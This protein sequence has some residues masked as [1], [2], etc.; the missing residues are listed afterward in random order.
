MNRVSWLIGLTVL[1][2]PLAAV[3]AQS[4]GNGDV[5]GDGVVNNADLQAVIR[6]WNTTSHAADQYGDGFVNGMDYTYVKGKIPTP[7]P[8]TDEWTQFG[9]DAQHT[10]DTAQVVATPWKYKWQWNGADATGKPQA[11]HLSVPRFVQPITGGGNVYIAAA[12]GV[13]ALS[14]TTGVVVWSNTALGILNSTPVYDN[15]SVYVASTNGSLY[16]LNGGSGSIAGTFTANGPLNTAPV[17]VGNLLYAVSYGGSLYAIDKR[18]LAKIWE[19]P[20]SSPGV[21]SAAYSPSRNAELFL[22]QDLYVHAVNAADG[23]QKWRVKPTGRTYECVSAGN[24]ACN[25]TSATGAQAQ[26][27]GPVIAEQHGIVFV[28]YRLNWQTLWTFGNYP[29]TN[30]AIR[31]DLTAQ[32]NQQPLFALNLDTGAQAFIPAVGNGGESDGGYLPIGPMPVVQV[33]GG[34]EVAYIQWRNGS[35]C[36]NSCDGRWDT[37]MGEMVLD[38][39]TV[40]G[41]QPG[42]LRFVQTQFFPTDETMQPTMSGNTYYINH[43]LIVASWAITNRATNLGS[44]FTTPI[45]ATAAPYVIWRE[46]QTATCSFN[47]STRYCTSLLSYGDTRTYGPGFYEYFGATNAAGSLAYTIVSNGLILVKAADGG[48]IALQNGNPTGQGAT[49][50]QGVQAK[51]L[52]QAPTPPGDGWVVPYED[53]GKY[54]GQTVTVDGTILSAINHLPKAVYLSFTSPHDGALL[55]QIFNRDVGKFPYD[56]TAI[57]GKHVQITGLVTLYPPEGV[58]PAIVV[59]EPGQIRILDD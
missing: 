45:Q 43:W 30:A 33:V 7:P 52:A 28:R 4:L 14:Q 37:T 15:G 47:A 49:T 46:A 53:A 59:T 39:T 2:L 50:Q 57:Q 21:T 32:P 8:Q 56:V 12:T 23:T 31:A 42:D 29:S 48:L 6:S 40:S 51:T 27:G 19:Y 20:A 11:N 44:T 13:Y 41:Y 55:V 5:T 24:D 16:E 10:N 54:I 38:S 58:G 26:N 36:P 22:S 3:Y 18:S 34:Q 25:V 17:L 35:S 9:H 1:L